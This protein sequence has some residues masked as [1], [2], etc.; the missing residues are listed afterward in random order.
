MVQ[1]TKQGCTRE[2]VALLV[3][4]RSWENSICTAIFSVLR[5][6]ADFATCPGVKM[7]R[8]MY[9][10]C[11]PLSLSYFGCPSIKCKN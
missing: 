4:L 2:R 10:L 9:T 5:I 6:S 8:L 1:G 7:Y 3:Q 11:Q